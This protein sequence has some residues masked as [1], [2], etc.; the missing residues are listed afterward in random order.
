MNMIAMSRPTS[1][2]VLHAVTPSAF[3]PTARSLAF[4]CAIL[5]H[6]EM[7]SQYFVNET[8]VDFCTS[9]VVFARLRLP[10]VRQKAAN[11]R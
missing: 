3:V 1:L 11:G 2:I 10:S 5:L 9:L 8:F 4:H 7:L 6:R